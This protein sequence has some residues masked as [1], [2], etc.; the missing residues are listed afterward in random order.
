MSKT[1]FKKNYKDFGNTEDGIMH[2]RG[3]LKC[4][5]CGNIIWEYKG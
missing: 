1:S 5:D 3:Y 2:N 4:F